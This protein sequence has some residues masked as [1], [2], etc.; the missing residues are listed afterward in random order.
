MNAPR[1]QRTQAYLFAAGGVPALIALVLTWTSPGLI[2]DSPALRWSLTVVVLGCWLIFA[3]TAREGI[4]ERLRTFSNIA[5]AVRDGEYDIRASGDVGDDPM[6]EIAAELNALGAAE[7]EHRLARHESDALL[8]KVLEEIEAGIFAFDDRERLR[9][10]N[11]RGARWLAR[12]VKSLLGESAEALG[13]KPCLLG[14]TPRV[15]DMAMP[16]G[17]A[18]YEIRRVTFR[19]DGRPHELLVMSDLSR[20]LAAEER[21]AWKRLVQVLRHEINNSLAPIRSIAA[22]LRGKLAR[23][24]RPP[25]WEEDLND[26]LEIIEARSDSLARLMA[27]YAQLT[28]L[29]APTRSAIDLGA[30]IARIAA[31]EDRLDVTVAPGPPLSLDA[32]ADQL[33]QA[34]INLI[35]NAADAA[36]ETGGGVQVRWDAADGGAA[37]RILIEDDGPGLADTENLFVPFFSTKPGGNGIGLVLSR[38]IAEAHGGRLV[39][40]NRDDARGCR[41][42]LQL[43]RQRP[44]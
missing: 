11:R 21:L 18:R 4:V 34:L 20:S 14:E 9:L 30:T 23:A 1:W 13:L 16:G 37:V 27:A 10:V 40:L 17:A 19:Q 32:D 25:Q 36:M 2:A 35:R 28:K 12:P 7:R 38:Q 42:T 39:I 8:G 5:S 41:V 24:P 26:G 6:A 43:P 33:E 3:F 44:R 15:A 29:P 31:L 22:T